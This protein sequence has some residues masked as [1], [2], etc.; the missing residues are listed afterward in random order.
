MRLREPSC[1]C[2]EPSSVGS[3]RVPGPSPGDGTGAARPLTQ[4]S[5]LSTSAFSLALSRERARVSRT[6]CV[7][8]SFLPGYPGAES[9]VLTQGPSPVG[10][11]SGSSGQFPSVLL[12]EPERAAARKLEGGRQGRVC[13]VCCQTCQKN[14]GLGVRKLV[15]WAYDYRVT[16]SEAGDVSGP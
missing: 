9:C 7:L 15:I 13:S 16:L 8:L 2:P 14:S 10:E 5:V 4:V 3:A 11:D 12:E 1:A 6:A